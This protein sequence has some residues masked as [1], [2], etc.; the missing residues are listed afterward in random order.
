[1]KV[2][3]L[4][5]FGIEN[6]EIIEADVPQPG[7][8]EVLVKFGGASVNYRDYQIVAGEFAPDQP[9][10]IIP[11]SDGAGEI[12]EVGDAVTRF[13]CGDRVSPLFFPNWL[14][15][16]AFGDVRA[17]SSGLEAPGVLR[18]YGVYDQDQLARVAPHLTDAQAACF[19]C[20]GLTAWTCIVSLSNIQS[21]DVVLVQGTGG[22][23]LFALRFAKAL[24][25]DVIITSG[26]D[27]KLERAKKLGADHC[28]NYRTTPDWGN[29]ARELTDGRGVDAVVEI[30]GTG[31][32]PQSIAAIRRGGHINIV[33]YLA[34]IDLGLSVFH[35]IERNA[36]LHG[37]SV[38]NAE[39][40]TEMMNFVSEYN[41]VPVIEK[42]CP[43]EEAGQALSSIVKGDHFGKLVINVHGR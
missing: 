4:P 26:S 6:L 1:M 11:V 29:L 28:I 36:H 31:T 2:M 39:G 13:A 33:G 41:L 17:I 9:L 16:E 19:P 21:G 3:Q 38:G 42:S 10:P 7:A 23:A 32:L 40:F 37:V 14:S 25:A 8:G 12:V 43:F 5:R 35:L 22:V 18:E 34:G 15:G 20:A 27:E 30:G 24:G